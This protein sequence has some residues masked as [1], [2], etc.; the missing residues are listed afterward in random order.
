M[1]NNLL[2]NSSSWCE[3][4]SWY[5]ERWPV[6]G[7]PSYRR[8]RPNQRR[9][10]AGRNNARRR[11]AC[12]AAR[13]CTQAIA[14]ASCSKSGQ[15][16]ARATL[17]AQPLCHARPAARQLHPACGGYQRFAARQP[18]P[19]PRGI[20][21]QPGPSR[22]RAETSASTVAAWCAEARTVVMLLRPSDGEEWVTMARRR[23]VSFRRPAARRLQP[24]RAGRHKIDRVELDEGAGVRRRTSRGR[25]GY[26]VRMAWPA[27]GAIVSVEDRRGSSVRP[28]ANGQRAGRSPAAPDYG[29]SA[30]VIS[31]SADPLHRQQGACP[32]PAAEPSTWRRMCRWI[33]QAGPRSFVYPKRRRN[34]PSAFEAA[35][36]S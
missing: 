17:D 20:D 24:A 27:F 10:V 2:G 14:A 33:A 7:C 28:P 35:P 1:G 8:S 11:A 30:C 6:S 34:G 9:C 18:R 26:T 16:V 5:S 29:D 32:T 21:P 23:R 4:H 19:R 3:R 12:C 13:S 25:V 36:A 31:R 15:E 22:D